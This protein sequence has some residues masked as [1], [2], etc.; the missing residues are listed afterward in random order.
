MIGRFTSFLAVV[1]LVAITTGAAQA[2]TCNAQA[3]AAFSPSAGCAVG[4]TNN[5]KI[6]PNVRVNQDSIFG[7]TD[8]AFI[9]KDNGLNGTDE[10]QTSALSL[11][12]SL[13][14]GLFEVASSIWSKYNKVMLVM[15]GGN[16]AS[17][18]NQNYV[19]HLLSAREGTYRTAFF[20]PDRNDVLKS[21]DISHITLY[22]ADIAAVPLPAGGLLLI[23][24]LGGLAALRR[25]KT[26]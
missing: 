5:D 11:T 10:G 16:N 8:W 20:E 14:S 9:A 26:A 3:Q 19:A 1:G 4:S 21:K 23:G 6:S 2:A 22:A 17:N 7:L 25:R 12:G 13:K 15:K 24:A 18:V